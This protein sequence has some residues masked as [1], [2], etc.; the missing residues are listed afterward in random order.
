MEQST[1]I[2]LAPVAVDLATNTSATRV[3]RAVYSS[4]P[5]VPWKAGCTTSSGRALPGLWDGAA[6]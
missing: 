5:L 1:G 4:C 6:S 3:S 2:L